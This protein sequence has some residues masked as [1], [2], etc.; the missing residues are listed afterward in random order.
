MTTP[1]YRYLRGYALD[2]GFSNR[3]DT[4]VINEVIYKIPW[5]E[6]LLPGP[7][8]EYL[9]VIDHDPASNTFYAPVNLNSVAVLSQ[10]GLSPSEGN[11]Q[12]HQQ[13]VYAAAMKTISHFEIAL[14]R[15]LMWRPKVTWV[16]A[17]G[18]K[19]GYYDL[20]FV[21]ALRIYPHA[22]R[23]ANAYYDQEKIA[24]LF[25]YFRSEAGLQ[26]N[27]FPGG[28]VFTCLSPDI[29]AHEITHAILDGM[30][31]RFTENTHPDV[32]AFHEGFADV[33][34]LLQRFT[35]TE[36]V[37]HQLNQCRGNLEEYNVLG[38]LATQFGNATGQHGALRSA[39]GD[40][41]AENG[42]WK[43]KAVNPDEYH[44]VFE[45][46]ERG[47]ILVATIFDAFNRIYHFKTKDLIRIATGGSGVLPEGYVSVDLVKRL[48][49]EASDI[50]GHMLHVCIRAVDYCPPLD[51]SFGDYLRA[52]ITADLD[53]AP[54]DENGYRIA[55]VEAFR[56][57]GIFPDRVNTLSVESLR[58]YPPQLT[59]QEKDVFKYLGDWLSKEL[60][61]VLTM[62][63]REELFNRTLEIQSAL[64]DLLVNN[65]DKRFTQDDW[66]NLLNKL[67]MTSKPV[68]LVYNS[69]QV[70]IESP[71]IEVHQLRPAFR[72][73]RE[74]RQK[75]QVIISIS[76]TIYLPKPPPGKKVQSDEAEVKFRG[77]C[78]LIMNLDDMSVDYVIT[79]NIKSQR[80]LDQQVAYQQGGGL[81]GFN[82]SDALSESDNVQRLNFKNLHFHKED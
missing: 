4:M 59:K 26:G 24:L 37:E 34:A 66:E 17:K 30:Q 21:K 53:I 10:I 36:L 67:G 22:F 7:V 76:Q 20:E 41:D 32:P 12:F 80:R 16:P 56:A 78:T 43:R 71:K 2:P 25:G 13:M 68:T 3:L 8:G 69:E 55:L 51:I 79:K 39:I 81:L 74:G 11:P 72:W 46:H 18:R 57:R 33:V 38:E 5:E 40:W 23:D 64:H 54:E 61:D 28:V 65:H 73:G 70:E 31:R 52:L 6:D 35:F 77:G 9:E 15:K 75:L 50:A 27:N 48:A 62:S 19:P 49:R 42:S 60:R 82:L 58:W 1:T 14:G 45:C 63:D 44:T 47:A 29:V